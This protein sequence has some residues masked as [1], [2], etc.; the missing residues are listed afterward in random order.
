[1]KKCWPFFHDWEIIRSID[2][3]KLKEEVIEEFEKKRGIKP[4]SFSSHEFHEG[5]FLLQYVEKICMKCETYVDE[6][7]PQMDVIRIEHFMEEQR[8]KLAEERVVR[9]KNILD[10]IKR[11]GRTNE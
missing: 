2:G 4:K 1:M 6:I 8:K 9:A 7:T 10:K 11:E 5:R 3:E